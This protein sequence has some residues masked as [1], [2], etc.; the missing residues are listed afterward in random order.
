MRVK[1]GDRIYD[2]SKE[3]IMLIFESDADRI[4]VAN[5]LVSMVEKEG[6]RKYLQAPD[7]ID[8]E[9]MK[10]FMSI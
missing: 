3:P 4:E 6:I 1:I 9:N 7:V 5:H 2:S 8:E 10:E